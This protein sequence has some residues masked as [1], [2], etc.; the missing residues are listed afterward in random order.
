MEREAL[1]LTTLV[2]L[3]DNLVAD[4]DVVELLTLLSDGCV[5][6]L[7]VDAAGIMLAAPNGELRVIASSSETMRSLELFEQQTAQGPCP[8]CYRTGTPIVSVDLADTATRWPRF[9]PEALAAGYRS[10]YALPMHLRD[11]TLGAL[12]LFRTSEYVMPAPD[13]RAAQA[14]ADVATIAILQ[15]RDTVAANV[16]GEQLQHALHSRL[17]IEQAKGMLA[18]RTGISIDEAFDQ[19]RRDARNNNRRLVDVAHALINC[20]LTTT[21]VHPASLNIL[22]APVTV[23]GTSF[24]SRAQPVEPASRTGRRQ[25]GR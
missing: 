6:A 23:A 13:V 21:P 20:N 10:V 17:T 2:G 1:L 14:L 24:K 8:D 5:E 19:L 3:A 15:H 4:F 25:R 9:A 12:N 18:E 22:A 7:D 11:K 16:I